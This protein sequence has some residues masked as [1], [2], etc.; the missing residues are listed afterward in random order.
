TVEL[1]VRLRPFERR[2]AAQPGAEVAPM[3]AEVLAQQ[4]FHQRAAQV[5]QADRFLD[6]GPR[7]D[8]GPTNQERYPVDLLE[9]R[10]PFEEEAVGAEVIAVVGGEDHD[11]VLELIALLERRQEPAE[12]IVDAGAGGVVTGAGL[13]HLL[14]AQLLPGGR[15]AAV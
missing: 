2:T 3:A 6:D 13:A 7:F 4:Q 11:R 8:A 9:R 10:D 5:E 15:D 1:R 14:V 12:L